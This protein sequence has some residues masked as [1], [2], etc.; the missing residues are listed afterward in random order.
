[1]IQRNINVKYNIIKKKLNNRNKITECIKM[2][3]SD[4]FMTL[5]Q[6]IYAVIVHIV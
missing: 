1:M 5:K 6:Y 4:V 2:N 3:Y